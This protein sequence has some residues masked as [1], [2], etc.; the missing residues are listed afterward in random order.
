LNVAVLPL[1]KSAPVD[2]H[3]NVCCEKTSSV[4]AGLQFSID[5]STIGLT[6]STKVTDRRTDRETPSVQCIPH[7]ALHERRAAKACDKGESAGW[8]EKKQVVG[9]SE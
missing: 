7:Y 5:R 1:G 9:R 4:S 6:V 2:F 3:K 8:Q